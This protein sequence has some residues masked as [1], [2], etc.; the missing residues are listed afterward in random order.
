MK[1]TFQQRKFVFSKLV[2]LLTAQILAIYLVAENERKTARED[3]I[4]E[5][6]RDEDLIADLAVKEATKL[7]KSNKKLIST[8][9]KARAKGAQ[10]TRWYESPNRTIEFKLPLT[11]PSEV[12]CK[13][14]SFS[15]TLSARDIQF[16]VPTT[17]VAKVNGLIKDLQNLEEDMFLKDAPALKLAMEKLEAKIEAL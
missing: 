11:T 13:G 8:R 3:E 5:L 7:E 14:L 9:Q 1:Y 17:H 12:P 15:S 6:L 16:R 2:S 4:L 10:E